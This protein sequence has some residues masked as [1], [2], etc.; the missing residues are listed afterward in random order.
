MSRNTLLRLAGTVLLCALLTG[1]DNAGIYA[2][3]GIS[4]PG[5]DLGPVHVNTGV[6]IGRWL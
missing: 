1:C 6:H 4:G 5:V 2:N 3:V